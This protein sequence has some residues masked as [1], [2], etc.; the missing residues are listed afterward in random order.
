MNPGRKVIKMPAMNTAFI[1][2]TFSIYSGAC[3]KRTRRF[4]FGRILSERASLP[5]VQ[6]ARSIPYFPLVIYLLIS[7]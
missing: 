4:L 1:A 7:L 6:M 3:A 5:A 2:S